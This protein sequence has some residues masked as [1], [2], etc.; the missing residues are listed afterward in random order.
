MWINWKAQ[1]RAR[2]II[3]GFENMTY[4]VGTI[5]ITKMEET[6][7]K[8]DLMRLQ[9]QKKSYRKDGNLLFSVPTEN[10]TRSNG[11][12]LQQ[13]RFRLHNRKNFPPMSMVKYWNW[14]PRQI[15]ESSLIKV[16][17][18]KLKKCSS[19]MFWTGVILPE[20]GLWTSQPPEVR[21]S[22]VFMILYN[23]NWTFQVLSN[24]VPL[25]KKLGI[26]L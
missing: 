25:R 3:R 11:L 18:C 22:L 7:L 10:K 15:V 16:F 4:D 26:A 21:F 14:L 5:I 23:S 20:A 12:K 2:K 13:E 24:S 17:T 1:K 8:G 6:R 19:G 9:I